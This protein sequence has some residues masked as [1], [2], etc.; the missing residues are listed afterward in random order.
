MRVCVCVSVA[1]HRV[2]SSDVDGVWRQIAVYKMAAVNEIQGACHI[3]QQT[4]DDVT[5]SAPSPSDVIMT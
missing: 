1:N 2:W 3:R 4:T 5:V